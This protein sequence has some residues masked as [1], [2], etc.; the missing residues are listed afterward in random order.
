MNGFNRDTRRRA[1]K[2]QTFS[3]FGF[4][5]SF[6]GNINYLIFC[7]GF[8]R[9]NLM[10]YFSWFYCNIK[11]NRDGIVLLA[12][13]CATLLVVIKLI[14]CFSIRCIQEGLEELG[15]GVGVGGVGG[16]GGST[17]DSSEDSQINLD[18]STIADRGSWVE[19]LLG[20]LRPVWTIIN[21]ATSNEIKASHQGQ[22]VCYL[23]FL[24]KR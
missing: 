24:L 5:Q 13:H 10:N 15:G 9:L 22:S 6:S 8:L 18:Q 3:F 12:V 1:Y 17:G 7:N 2:V 14:D 11:I 16:G 4:V 21:K 23:Y 20:C 19:G